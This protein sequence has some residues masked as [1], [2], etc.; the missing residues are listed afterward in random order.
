VIAI[1]LWFI[2]ILAMQKQFGAFLAAE[3]TAF[4]MLLPLRETGP[5]RI[6]VTMV[7]GRVPVH[8]FLSSPSDPVGVPVSNDYS[9]ISAT[10]A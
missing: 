7:L 2:D 5:W 10:I 6:K 1:C 3:L 9:D 8:D 4:S